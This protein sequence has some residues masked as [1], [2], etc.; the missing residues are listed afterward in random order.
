MP[1]I[2]Y[3]MQ[4]TPKRPRTWFGDAEVGS[5]SAPAR[6]VE[7][8]MTKNTEPLI[9]FPQNNIS[10]LVLLFLDTKCN[11][12]TTGLENFRLSFLILE[13]KHSLRF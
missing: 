6:V 9:M 12:P 1:P 13:G 8:L 7:A 3:P 5:S 4:R 11:T 10:N 2:K